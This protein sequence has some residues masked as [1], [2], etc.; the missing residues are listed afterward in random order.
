M[1]LNHD[2]STHA[3]YWSW[4]MSTASSAECHRTNVNWLTY[5]SRYKV[6]LSISDLT[7]LMRYMSR[8]RLCCTTLTL[9]PSEM[10]V[11]NRGNIW[12]NP[13]SVARLCRASCREQKYK[14][15]INITHT[16]V[17]H[18]KRKSLLYT[19]LVPYFIASQM[20]TIDTHIFTNHLCNCEKQNIY[21]FPSA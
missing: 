21:A 16:A 15:H 6:G 19:V 5:F 11:L 10:N 13:G 3:K 12:C 9:T 1:N 14:S 7:I 18:W 4:E 2:L 17:A 20:E 8:A